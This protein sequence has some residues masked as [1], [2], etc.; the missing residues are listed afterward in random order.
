MSVCVCV[1]E[2]DWAGLVVVGTWKQWVTTLYMFVSIMRSRRLDV[3]ATLICH[4]INVR[5]EGDLFLIISNL[6]THNYLHFSFVIWIEHFNHRH[7]VII[8]WRN[9]LTN[10]NTNITSRKLVWGMVGKNNL[11]IEIS[12]TLPIQWPCMAI[13]LFVWMRVYTYLQVP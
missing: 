10:E 5:L 13:W 6:F 7:S 9:I 8:L 1:C 4:D 11:A 2:R 12:I 3:M